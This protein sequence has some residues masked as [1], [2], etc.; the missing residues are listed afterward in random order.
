MSIIGDIYI[1]R[2]D[3]PFIIADCEDIGNSVYMFHMLNMNTGEI[4]NWIEPH[5][6]QLAPSYWTYLG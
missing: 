6:N 1:N 2:Q 4:H 5:S 3:T